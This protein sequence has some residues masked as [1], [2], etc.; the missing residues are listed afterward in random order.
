MDHPERALARRGVVL[1]R[2][3]RIHGE[4]R[5]SN[6]RMEPLNLRPL[7]ERRLAPW[8]P[9]LVRESGGRIATSL[10]RGLQMEVESA[11]GREL[12]KLEDANV[13]HAA[14]VV[15]DNASGGI[16]ALVS[17]G[18]WEDPRGG[19]I[20]GALT[21]RSPGSTLKPFTYLLS[22][23]R[24]G[25]HPGSIVADIPTRIR[26]IEG[27]DAPENYDRSFRGPV[28]I[29]QALACSLNVP[30][31]RELNRLG[32]PRP[33][34]ELLVDLGFHSLGEDS[35]EHG[36]GLTIGNAPV[37]LLELTQGYAAIARGG[38][39]RKAGLM[40]EDHTE[41]RRFSETSAFL[42]ADI[43]S[44]PD[45]RAPSFGRRG[46]LELPFPCAAKT[47]TS[48]DFR[49]NWCVGFTREFT[50][51]VWA[52]NFDHSPMKGVSGV[53][54]AGPIFHHTMLAL[55]PQLDGTLMK[56]PAGLVRARMDPRNGK[57]VTTGESVLEWLPP[58][59]DPLP[60]L[61]ND[62]DEQGRAILDKSYGEWLASAY[63]R[64]RGELAPEPERPAES[65]LRVLAPRP[66]T[67]YLLD[68]ELP[69]GGRLRLATNLPG[70]ARWS[71]ES[72]T[73]D[74]S[75]YEPIAHLKPGHHELEVTDLRNGHTTRMMIT[76][77]T[78]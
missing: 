34:H 60:A 78:R 6:A 53:D 24:G 67:V 55:H 63:N 61:E 9:E 31:M 77:E 37:S 10:D 28:T 51:G 54:G 20:N 56:R 29:R 66:G 11:V 73:L 59:V 26:T 43:L 65:P 40:G 23:E 3:A 33:L 62:Y 68:P 47:G 39:F 2:L 17:S 57:R 44:D 18:D 21:P 8:L 19:Q 74:E 14:V 50:V 5:I 45:A 32:G 72:L 36:L 7:R 16:L 41:E 4:P 38:L 1:D 27:L 49:D 22:F 42:V 71:C 76:V 69:N 15:I 13:Q 64:R 52:G 48:S 70:V 12:A 30:A 58:G 35:E 46:P 75:A 25:R